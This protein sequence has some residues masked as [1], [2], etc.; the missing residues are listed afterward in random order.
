MIEQHIAACNHTSVGIIVRRN[1]QLLLLERQKFP[2]G[3]AAPAGHV[4]DD[5]AYRDAAIRE[6]QEE[7]GLH[8]VSLSLL[9]T[10]QVANQCRRP[11]GDCHSW[12]IYEAEVAGDLIRNVDEAKRLGW[13]S[14]DQVREMAL[15]T[16]WYLDG[17]IAEKV[18]QQA[19]GL[20]PVWYHFL[21]HLSLLEDVHHQESPMK[22]Q[23]VCL[24]EKAQI[25][26]PGGV[27]K[28]GSIWQHTDGARCIYAV[29]MIGGVKFYYALDETTRQDRWHVQSHEGEA[30]YQGMALIG[31]EKGGARDGEDSNTL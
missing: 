23:G 9:H 4:E 22:P 16:S 11:G 1:D 10:E 21:K 30:I 15:M 27:V 25:V 28:E 14:M 26:F 2:W 18:W 29:V 20:E 19:P 8:V 12:E 3:F 17:I 13:Y 7:T 31:K 6:L 24:Q 5:E